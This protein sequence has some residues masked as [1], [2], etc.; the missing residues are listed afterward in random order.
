M[1]LILTQRAE[2]ETVVRLRQILEAHG[3]DVVIVAPSTLEQRSALSIDPTPRAVLHLEHRDVQLRE[4]EA[5]WL[6]RSWRPQRLLPQFKE[7]REQQHTWTFFEN[8]WVAFHKGFSMLLAQH[9]VFC[10]NPPPFN[11]AYEEKIC[12]LFVAAQVGLTIPSSLYTT[13]LQVAR[14]F[15]EQHT[16]DII[17]KPFRAYLQVIEPRGDESARA[18]RLLTNR[19]QP[20]ELEEPAD[21]VP[22][23]G[24]FQ[25]Y[26]AKALELRIV[27]VGNALFACAIHSQQSDLSRE[28]W[29]RYDFANTPYEAYELPAEVADKI[30]QLMDRLG[31]V[32]GSVDIVLTPDGEYVFL[33]V[34]P[35]GQFDFVARLTGMP[36]Y[37]HL[38]AM[39]MARSKDYPTEHIQAVPYVD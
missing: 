23:P 39:L 30:R 7:L 1:L 15:S 2:D 5:A 31:L 12:Q 27:V 8:E 3:T 38:A 10:V 4:V 29:R 35:N 20:H 37:E 21:F 18:V 9:D 6:W 24:I 17:Y 22:T 25:P 28:D 19:V 32:F 26:I 11:S 34:N 36:I 16:D 14:A 13:R 33:E